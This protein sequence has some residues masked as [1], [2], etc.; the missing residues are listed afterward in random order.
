MSF[1]DDLFKGKA[2]ETITDPYGT[3]N[4]LQ[5]T[6]GTSVSDYLNKIIKG[7]A[8]S[9]TGD[10]TAPLTGGESDAISRNARMSALGEQ[11]LNPLLQGQFPEDYYQ[12]Y[13][14]KPAMKE[15]TEDI[16][17]LIEEQYAGS[18]GYWGGARADAVG[19][20]YRDL[21]DKLVAERSN[22]GYQAMRDVPTAINAANALSQTEAAMQQTPRLIKQYGLDQQYKE[23][24]R[25]QDYTQQALNQALNFLNISTVTREEIE[26]RPSLFQQVAGSGIFGIGGSIASDAMSKYPEYQAT[27]SSSQATM[28][29]IMSMMGAGGGGG[30]SIPQGGTSYGGGSWG[31]S[32]PY[33]TNPNISSY[34]PKPQ[35]SSGNASRLSAFTV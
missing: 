21:T 11:G 18:G 14:R 20:G 35:L 27:A 29:A 32:T 15:Y 24:I 12:N 3:W 34:G 25:S 6:T 2:S 7:G 31:S 4:P 17:P 33:Y 5:R 9:Y 1:W 30:G 26:G 13:I 16:A 10:Y 22:L 19:K 8:P 28:D 23:W